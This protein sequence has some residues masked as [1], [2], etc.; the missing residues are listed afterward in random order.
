M[1][2]MFD[3]VSGRYDLLN[4]LMSL[5]QDRAWRAALWRAVP[6]QAHVVLDLCTGSGASLPG[7][8]RPGRLVLGIDVSS[9]MLTIAASRERTT[10]W[11]PRLICADAFQLPFADATIDAITIAFG[12]RNLRPSRHALREL[13][14]VLRPDGALAVLEATAPRRGLAAPLH[15]LY[16]RHVI[17]LA[18]RL[19]KDPTAYAY[20]SRSIFE[21]GTGSEFEAELAEAE[22][23][24]VERRT[25]LV[26]ATGL[27]LARRRPPGGQIA[28]VRP[29]AL[30]DARPGSSA[31]GRPLSPDAQGDQEWRLWVGTQLALAAALTAA[32]AW[33]LWVFANYA[34]AL[35]LATW[36][37]RLAWGLLGGGLGLFGVR[38]LILLVRF[39]GPASRL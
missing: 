36:E 34:N 32:L 31:G 23:E 11:A 35:P 14:R 10:G 1:A 28:S 37:R 19:S 3:E 15:R 33:G 16:L 21:F 4:R 18:G 26:G 20:L 39:A 17:P 25:F 6:E 5:G 2:G 30:Q 8:R 9:R 13:G 29:P 22:F 7:L 24:L 27:W 12:M 38:T